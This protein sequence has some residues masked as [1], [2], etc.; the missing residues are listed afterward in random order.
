[1]KKVLKFCFIL[2]ICLILFGCS[3][4]SDSDEE[5]DAEYYYILGFPTLEL[6]SNVP[7]PTFGEVSYENGKDYV[8]I[9]VENSTEDQVKEYIS[10]LV[11]YGWK[12]DDSDENSDI[13]F[14]GYDDKNKYI[15]VYY[16]EE[17]MTIA[18]YD[19]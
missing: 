19:N 3:S 9:Y 10:S 13:Y 11:N 2:L 18:V 12:V 15:S 1:M 6:V 16:Y 14:S 17:E 5:Y 7:Q 8:Y 4:K